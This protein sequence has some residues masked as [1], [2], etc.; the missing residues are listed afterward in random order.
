MF[1]FY[2]KDLFIIFVKIYFINPVVKLFRDAV[3]PKCILTGALCLL[4]AFS[5]QIQQMKRFIALLVLNITS[6]LVL[7]KFII[8]SMV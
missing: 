8:N 4:P 1:F 5:T 2:I 3:V 7:S 6:P